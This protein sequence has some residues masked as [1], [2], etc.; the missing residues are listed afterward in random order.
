MGPRLFTGWGVRTMAEGD[1]AYSPIGY[2]VGTVW[3]HDTSIIAMGLRRYGYD[4]EAARLAYAMLEAATF[5][6]GR[7][8]EAFAGHPRAFTEFPV[9]YPT[10]CSPQA[11][12][13]GAPLAMLRALLG[14]EPVGDHLLV[15]PAVPTEIEQLGLTNIPGRWGRADA[16]ARGR[17]VLEGDAAPRR[18]GV[19]PAVQPS[20]SHGQ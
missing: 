19:G 20:L 5:F 9:E 4:R 14:L 8:P 17:I 18:A 11:W 10:A 1:G 15:A 16:F 6:N 13:T 3:P 2:H 12:A 7:L